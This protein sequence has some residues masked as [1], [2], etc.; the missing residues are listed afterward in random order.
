M[1]PRSLLIRRGGESVAGRAVRADIQALRAVAVIGVVIYHLAP[2]RLTGGFMGVDVF[3]VISGYLMT[4]TIW[5]GIDAI[6]P[7]RGAR[8]GASLRF[9]LSFYA[10]RIKRLTPAATVCLL[11][12]L[13]TAYLSGDYSMQLAVAPQVL[14]SAVFMQNWFLA[15]QAVDYLGADAGATAVQ[16]FWSLSVEEQFYMVWPLILLAAALVMPAAARRRRGAP[17]LKGGRIPLAAVCLFTAASLVFGAWLTSRNASWAYF[18]T[19]ARIWELS[20]GGVI[21]F[22]PALRLR[23]GVRLLLPWLGLAVIAYT[24]AQWDG[25]AFPGLKAL[26]PTVGALLVIW[27]G[28]GGRAGALSVSS[29]SRF[30]PA[31]FFG[32]IS[33]SL[34]LWHW[35]PLVFLP[36]AAGRPL[37]SREL[38]A[39]LFLSIAVAW[40]SYR[41]VETPFRKI[42]SGG[43]GEGVRLPGGSARVSAAIW[44]AG[45][46]CMTAILVS[47]HL[48]ETSARTATSDFVEYAYARSV[49]AGDAGFGAK[50][51]IHAGEPGAP[52]NPFGGM[53]DEWSVYA[54]GTEF[55]SEF[56][57]AG[58]SLATDMNITKVGFDNVVTVGDK[59]AGRYIL[60]LGDSHMA[61]YAPALDVLGKEK[62]YRVVIAANH[63][64]CYPVVRYDP[65]LD[66]WL[67]RRDQ[68]KRDDRKGL[69][70]YDY[71]RD[72]YWE[73]A[74]AIIISVLGQGFHRD[75]E[76]RDSVVRAL[77]DTMSEIA[78]TNGR[79][80][81]LM[82]DIPR[83][84]GIEDKA[85]QEYAIDGRDV[86]IPDAVAKTRF[87]DTLR[88]QLQRLCP[89][90]PYTY[91]ETKPLLSDGTDYHTAVG[92]LPVY[93]D[94]G[95]MNGLFSM[96]M[97]EYLYEKICR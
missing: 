49:S 64:I 88:D 80:A 92:G 30:R 58:S 25:S 82:Q 31:Q 85:M 56:M 94:A 62:G 71:I 16:H 70:R 5:S 7:Q 9:L 79:P 45:A 17:S 47:S 33:Y 69:R 78:E 4:K 2:E 14:A 51:V 3:F 12:V 90:A 63:S 42:G 6:P 91:I 13:A 10:R 53:S 76:S 11:A 59:G 81:F 43:A 72:T 26:A 73:G 8:A 74:D 41:F 84:S 68:K 29:V 27:G 18:M 40:V 32:D 61:M 23:G 24:F 55:V 67:S 19:P 93:S 57:P 44:L 46:I 86:P 1:D 65:S 28:E 77:G 83:L 60:A 35:P 96:S 22:L 15:S 21:V 38:L 95:H 66:G 50:A 52:E 75:S 20:L 37:G 89:D 54:R 97:W 34:Y 36:M 48:V 39:V 87:C